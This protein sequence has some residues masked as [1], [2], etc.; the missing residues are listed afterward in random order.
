M[1]LLLKTKHLNMWILRNIF[2]MKIWQDFFSLY[3]YSVLQSIQ[4]CLRLPN[5]T[6]EQKSSCSKHKRKDFCV[7]QPRKEMLWAIALFLFNLSFQNVKTSSSAKSCQVRMPII[8]TCTRLSHTKAVYILFVGPIFR[9]YGK[10]KLD[11]SYIGNISYR[12]D[13]KHF[14]SELVP[15]WQYVLPKHN[16]ICKDI[17]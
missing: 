8:P 13:L 6:V 4:R 14:W 2:K 12:R 15:L 17:F 9:I 1:S 7:C 3:P 5:R 16:R 10:S 11:I